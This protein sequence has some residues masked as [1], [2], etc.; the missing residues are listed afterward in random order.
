[1]TACDLIRMITA[2]EAAAGNSETQRP[3]NRASDIDRNGLGVCSQSVGEVGKVLALVVDGL[4]TNFEVEPSIVLVASGRLSEGLKY[5]CILNGGAHVGLG[6]LA[7]F[8]E[9]VVNIDGANLLAVKVVVE[10]GIALVKD[11]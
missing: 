7:G 11:E 9:E 10:G 6:D 3:L 8:E 2:V 4:A 1:M 5:G